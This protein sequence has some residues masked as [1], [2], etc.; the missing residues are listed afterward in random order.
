MSKWR[1]NKNNDIDK[2]LKIALKNINP[3]FCILNR[4]IALKLIIDFIYIFEM[5][6]KNIIV[7]S[8]I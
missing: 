5:T 2:I 4:P 8:E 6:Y 3:L 1:S 7:I